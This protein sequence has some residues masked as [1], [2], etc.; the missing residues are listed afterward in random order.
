MLKHSPVSCHLQAL[1]PTPSAPFLSPL[2]Q[3]KVRWDSGPHGSVYQYAGI[4]KRTAR[5]AAEYMLGILHCCGCALK[6]SMLVSVRA[7]QSRYV[8]R[9]ALTFPFMTPVLCP[10]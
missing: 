5:F 3:P 2:L 1:L 4:L 8:V 7:C 10:Q 9:H 6:P